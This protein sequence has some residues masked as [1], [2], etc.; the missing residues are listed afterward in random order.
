MSGFDIIGP[1]DGIQIPSLPGLKGA[2]EG[3]RGGAAAERAD[4]FIHQLSEALDGVQGLSDDVKDKANALAMGQPVEL[5]DL[6]ISMGKS[7]VAF[8]LM[9][10]VRNKL[11]D[12]W[13]ALSRAV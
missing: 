1:K 10:E 8:N 6:M 7:E 5:H 11:L 2:E 12:A 9:L 3:I 13:Q 4:G